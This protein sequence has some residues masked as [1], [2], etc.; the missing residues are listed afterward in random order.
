MRLCS[1]VM[2]TI[3]MPGYSSGLIW[4]AALLVALVYS[5]HSAQR[6]GLNPRSMYWAVTLS[7]VGGLW[8]GNLLGL[9]VHGWNGSVALLTFWEGGKSWYGG[10]ILGG[11]VGGLFFYFRKLP[12]LAYADASV[13]AVALGYCVGRLGCF[14]N[15]DDFGTLSQLP[16]AVTYS[17]GTAAYSDHLS[18]GWIASG[19][20]ASLPIHPVQLYALF[21]GLALF[22][23]LA[24]WRPRH[25]GDRLST[26]LVLYGAARFGMEPWLR[27]DFRAVVGPLSPPQVFSLLFLACGVGVWAISRRRLTEQRPLEIATLIS[28]VAGD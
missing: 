11:L 20:A 3:A 6:S 7:I 10:A 1:A 26:F 22:V 28:F 19:A 14:L 5:V 15:G 13:P 21:L 12:V 9:L 2:S 16:W 8:G 23:L 24:N 18:R 25:S 4:Y 27:G 17:P